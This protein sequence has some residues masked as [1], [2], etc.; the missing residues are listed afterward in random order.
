MVVY[1]DGYPCVFIFLF[2]IKR[3]R[4]REK[5]DRKERVDFFSYFCKLYFHRKACEDLEMREIMSIFAVELSFF[6]KRYLI[7]GEYG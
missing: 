7:T 1:S 6:C 5:N 2:F 3:K 4:L